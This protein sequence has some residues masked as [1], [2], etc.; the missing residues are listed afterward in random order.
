[1]QLHRYAIALG[2]NRPHGRHGAPQAVIGAALAALAETDIGLLATSSIIA[3]AP[4]GAACR[5]FA[6]A[7]AIV[8][9][10]LEPAALLKL[11]KRIE[12]DFGRR[13]GRRWG[14]RV[15]DLDILLWSG[16]RWMQ[17]TARDALII[18]HRH[19]YSRD[20]VLR[21]LREI[22]ATW[23]DRRVAAAVRHAYVRLHRA[24]PV[25]RVARGQ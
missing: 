20:F 14:D 2:S 25:D 18:P 16:G 24:K 6:N 9:T 11:L 17:P 8:E 10:G 3:T 19:I 21:P 15:V 23:P 22:A 4:I 1:M 12:R 13:R 5:R 7:A